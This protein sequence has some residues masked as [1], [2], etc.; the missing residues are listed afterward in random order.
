M[1]PSREEALE[2]LRAIKGS[3]ERIE[4][5]NALRESHP[6]WKPDLSDSENPTSLEGVR[7]GFKLGPDTW[8]GAN[9]QNASLFAVNL[10]NAD[11]HGVNMNGANLSH[12]ILVG[13]KIRYAYLRHANLRDAHL[14]SSSLYRSEI[15]G[16]D[17]QGADLS[18]THVFSI[19]YDRSMM[20]GK[21][22]G[23][24]GLISCYGDAVFRRDAIDQDYI[25]TVQKRWDKGFKRFAFEVWKFID[26]GRGIRRVFLIAVTLPTL[27]GVLY[28]L[29]KYLEW[30]L[31]SYGDSADT[32][33]TPFYYSIVTYTTL[34]FGD[35]LPN[36]MFGES[37]VIVEVIL[38]YLTLGLIVAILANF[39]ARRS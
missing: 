12:A 5:W 4:K 19:K 36:S 38:G 6:D 9:L 15:H 26:F 29:D 8:L 2:Q 13:A 25:D 21:Y 10:T 39:V 16:A 34:G 3:K 20:L 7:L 37:I 1:I 24:R 27:F 30:G 31:L 17:F 33:L 22:R 18:E 35:V 11:L 28:S 14:L 32:W 23:A